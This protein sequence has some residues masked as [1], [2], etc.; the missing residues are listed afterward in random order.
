VTNITGDQLIGRSVVELAGR[1][2]PVVRT[3]ADVAP[4]EALALVGSGGRLEIAVRNGHAARVLG[5]ARGSRVIL[6]AESKA[7]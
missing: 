2:I 4:G 7:E 3:Y 1:E 5:L 6:S